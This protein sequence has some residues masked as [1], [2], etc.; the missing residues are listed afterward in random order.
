MNKRKRN[1]IFC[2]AVGIITM[3][4]CLLP[5]AVT[6]DVGEVPRVSV[7]IV[8][9]NNEMLQ[10]IGFVYNGAQSVTAEILEGTHRGEIVSG[11]NYMNAALDKDKLFE[12]GDRA[13]AMLHETSDSVTLTLVDHDRWGKEALLFVGFGVLLIL[14]GGVSGCGALISLALSAVILWKV[15][16]PL[17]LTGASPIWLSL[18]LVT[19]LTA[20]ID[21]LVAGFHRQAV[22]AFLGSMLGT[23]LTCI[24]AVVCGNWLGLSG[25]QIPYVVPL[26]SQGKLSI[27]IEQLFFAMV[28]I[29]NAGAL[30]DLS[31]DISASCR[32]VREH[33]PSLSRMELMKSGFR[34]GRSV[35]GTM[36]TTLL[37]AYSGSYL[38]MLMYFAGQ[39]T[40]LV[41]I[42]NYR[43]VAS[44]ILITLVGSFGLVTVAPFTAM[45]SAWIFPVVETEANETALPSQ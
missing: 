27:D 6:S 34:V 16:I 22:A 38:S 4:L 18:L 42:L 36:S 30:M 40:P 11:C 23:V 33:C 8:S 14:F 21:V 25:G 19:I 13:I 45:V 2:V 12:V 44:E 24:M 5:D 37:L 1:W 31:M 39:G 10:P 15:F 28:F 35:I 9:V 17:L 32:E 3:L 20:V 41:D 43:F 29:S 26:I 7:Q